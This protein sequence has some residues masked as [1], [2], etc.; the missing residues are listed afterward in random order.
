[1]AELTRFKINNLE[2][3]LYKAHVK[4]HGSRSVDEGEF[5]FPPST[6]VTKGDCVTYIQDIVD[7]TN[8]TAIY[9]FQHS[10]RDEGGFCLD[11]NDGTF[12]ADFINDGTRNYTQDIDP[13][14]RF[15]ADCEFVTV[16]DS[17]RFDFS[18]QFDIHTW[19]RHCTFPTA[20]KTFFSKSTGGIGGGIEIGVTAVD[21]MCD[22]FVCVEL[23][24]T[25]GLLTTIT[26]TNVSISDGEYHRVRIKRDGAGDIKVFTDLTQE[27]CTVN[28]NAAVDDYTASGTDLRFGKNF[29]AGGKH[30]RGAL[31]QV[32]IYSGGFLT[33]LDS[34]RVFKNK[35][36][37]LTMKFR[38]KVSKVENEQ[39]LKTVWA[40]G[41]NDIL[42]D[43]KITKSV[44][45]GRD[46]SAC[47]NGIDNVFLDD[48]C[49]RMRTDDIICKTLLPF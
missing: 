11:G 34:D 25:G 37:P 28:K 4:R 24:D 40:K 26:G 42:T 20:A 18:K 23:F 33:D 41:V 27:G 3:T 9:N 29:G 19:V 2:S 21:C 14:I 15:N 10:A 43:I 7:T 6:V 45:D 39:G 22:S 13:A 49:N 32:R 48:A 44:M 16:T 35:R 36:Q 30:Y 17:T 46:D 5:G 8:L 47:C 1:M 31:A 38:G 12:T